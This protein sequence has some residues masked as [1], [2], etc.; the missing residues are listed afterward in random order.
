MIC[1]EFHDQTSTDPSQYTN[2]RKFRFKEGLKF[3]ISGARDRFTLHIENTVR[4]QEII[5]NE[6]KE[7]RREKVRWSGW[8]ASHFLHTHYN[9]LRVRLSLQLQS[10]PQNDLTDV[11]VILKIHSTGGRLTEW[12]L[13]DEVA[14]L[15]ITEP[16]TLFSCSSSS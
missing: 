3:Q 2:V 1:L 9:Y 10:R 16:R 5:F 12:D 14:L 13:R 15:F 7:G 11:S 6:V 4:C 8:R